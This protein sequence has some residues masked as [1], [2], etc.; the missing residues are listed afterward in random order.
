MN[1]MSKYNSDNRGTMIVVD[2][3]FLVMSIIS[4]I[5]AFVYMNSEWAWA[6]TL[7]KGV[8]D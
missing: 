5:V 2:I 7:L 6:Y 3:S 8:R 4:L 1:S